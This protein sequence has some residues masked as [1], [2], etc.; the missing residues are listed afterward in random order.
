MKIYAHHMVSRIDLIKKKCANKFCSDWLKK[1][2]K[3]RGWVIVLAAQTL[4][5][6][7]QFRQNKKENHVQLK[8]TLWFCKQ[9]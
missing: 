8:L 4:A 7:W 1:L 6:M 2:V 9:Y 3:V 5:D